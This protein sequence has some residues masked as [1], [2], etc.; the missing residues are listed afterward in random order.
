MEQTLLAHHR[1]EAAGREG[2]G[3][4]VALHRAHQP[5]QA[6]EPRQPH[7]RPRAPGV[8]VERSD[9]GAEP[10]GEEARGPA[11]AGADVEDAAA[12]G[13][14]GPPGQRLH[15]GHASVVVLVPREEVLGRGPAGGAVPAGEPA[16]HVVLVDGMVIVVAGDVGERGRHGAGA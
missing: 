7:A 11:E 8:Q 10:V 12:R 5:L 1:G 14:S 16:Q 15:R 4:R 2:Q 9:A 13:D 3:L 6:H